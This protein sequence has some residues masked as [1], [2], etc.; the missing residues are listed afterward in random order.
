MPFKVTVHN[1]GLCFTVEKEESIL[2]AAKRQ[3]IFLPYGCDQGICGAC[4]YT[5]IKGSVESPDGQPFAL[6]DEDLEA[7]QRLCCVG[8]AVSDLKIK[9]KYPDEDFEPWQ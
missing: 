5:I 3:G 9:L 8:H 4:M 1:T 2:A 6:F 7:G